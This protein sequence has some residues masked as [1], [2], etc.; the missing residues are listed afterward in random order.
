MVVKIS[1]SFLFLLVLVT[2]VLASESVGTVSASH[3][4][5]WG[6]N[7]GWINLAPT[8]SSGDFV[9]VTITDSGLTGYGW[10]NKYG[11]INFNPS[12]SDQSVT[13]TSSGSLGGSAW[14]SGLGWLDLSGISISS[15]GVFTGTAG[16]SGST[17]GRVTFDCDNCSVQTDWRP[18]SA[19]TTTSSG[20]SSGTSGFISVINSGVSNFWDSFSLPWF[21]PAPNIDGKYPESVG[22]ILVNKTGATTT[23][24]TPIFSGKKEKRE[25]EKVNP[26]FSVRDYRNSFRFFWLIIIL[27]C[28]FA[29]WWWW[30]MK[31]NK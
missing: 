5:A 14:V 4:Y 26:A 2:P 17:V 24:G 20:S 30:R 1:F 15:S 6:E 12:S 16:T 7:I 31:Y 23:S 27:L 13:N 29:L 18:A 8:N 3:Q 21:A 19:R 11:W 9:G 22:S 25:Q 28:T 10:S